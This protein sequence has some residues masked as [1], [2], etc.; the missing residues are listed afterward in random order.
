MGWGKRE[1][2]KG[3]IRRDGVEGGEQPKKREGDSREV[4]EAVVRVWWF[5]GNP[6]PRRL[7]TQEVR[8]LRSSAV[9]AE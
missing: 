5:W 7:L 2:R 9:V 3:K 1:E 8:L 4:R 6:P